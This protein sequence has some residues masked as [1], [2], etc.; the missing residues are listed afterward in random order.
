M[1]GLIYFSCCSGTPRRVSIWP[2]AFGHAVSLVFLQ[3][4][5]TF[6][7]ANSRRR[8][9]HHVAL[10]F[11]RRMATACPSA[12]LSGLYS[13]QTSPLATLHSWGYSSAIPGPDA[14]LRCR[15]SL[16]RTPSWLSQNAADM[17]VM[18]YQSPPAASPPTPEGVRTRPVISFRASNMRIL[19]RAR[20]IW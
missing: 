17:G 8:P 12:A 1:H 14:T 10:S 5:R 19:M 7:L 2:F 3:W 9:V 15:R 11:S 18:A 4:L 16:L 13:G 20:I 6:R